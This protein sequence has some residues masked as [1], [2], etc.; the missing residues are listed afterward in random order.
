M[1]SKSAFEELAR[2]RTTFLGPSMSLVVI[3]AHGKVFNFNSCILLG[4]W[5]RMQPTWFFHQ[6]GDRAASELLQS[7][8]TC[9]VFVLW[10][11]GLF[12]FKSCHLISKKIIEAT[13]TWQKQRQPKNY[14]QLGKKSWHPFMNESSIDF[15]LK[16]QSF[17]KIT[18]MLLRVVLVAT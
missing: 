9:Q 11:A 13:D 5:L 8:R 14:S 12:Q 17:H 7:W 3:T 4:D 2:L 18:T 16:L 1:T 15:C 10:F 6:A